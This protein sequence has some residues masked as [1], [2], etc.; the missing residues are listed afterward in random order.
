[1][2]EDQRKPYRLARIEALAELLKDEER[3]PLSTVRE[4]LS[5]LL[6]TA[7]PLDVEP[8]DPGLDDAEFVNV[9]AQNLRMPEADR[10]ELLERNSVLARA[11][12]LVARLE[13]R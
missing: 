3:G 8:P 7:L 1:M 6:Y 11:R 4:R 10:Q 2:S 13:A 12:A 9:T 5:Q